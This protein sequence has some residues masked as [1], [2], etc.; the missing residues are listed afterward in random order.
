MHR[1]VSSSFHLHVFALSLFLQIGESVKQLLIIVYCKWDLP[2]L[3][4]FFDKSNMMSSHSPKLFA[5]VW[6]QSDVEANKSD[7]DKVL[8]SENFSFIFC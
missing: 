5:K 1:E 2:F 6:E 3:F 7:S 8:I 4:F